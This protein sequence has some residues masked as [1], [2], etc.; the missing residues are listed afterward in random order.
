MRLIS[1]N[2]ALKTRALFSP[3]ILAN[4]L[5]IS[6]SRV[7]TAYAASLLSR[8]DRYCNAI[9][10]DK[11]FECLSTNASN[12]RAHLWL[13]NRTE[14]FLPTNLVNSP[15][16]GAMFMRKTKPCASINGPRGFLLCPGGFNKIP[17]FPTT[18][19]P[20]LK[21]KGFGYP[22]HRLVSR[23]LPPPLAL[24]TLP[25]MLFFNCPGDIGNNACASSLLI[26]VANSCH[27]DGILLFFA[28]DF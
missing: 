28:S 27:A 23:E 6:K 21:S 4:F 7:L 25:N 12:S 1:T 10:L 3:I 14:V 22:F 9:S 16:V 26:V 15:S 8:L 2:R 24:V 13:I 18:A 5:A 20:R 19:Q 17:E 11:T